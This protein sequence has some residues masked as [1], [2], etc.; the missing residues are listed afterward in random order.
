MPGMTNDTP[1]KMPDI[2]KEPGSDGW[3]TTEVAGAALKR[4]PRT[5]KR[6]IN[7]GEL[8]GRQ[9]KR[10]RAR[11]WEVDVASLKALRDRWVVEGRLDESATDAEIA[12]GGYEEEDRSEGVARAFERIAQELADARSQVADAQARLELTTRAESSTKDELEIERRRRE[13]I[14][15]QLREARTE[16]EKERSKSLWQRFFD[17][18]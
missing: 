3:T 13:H 17:Y 1:D 9:V 14:E 12:A 16:L 10:G 15:Q 4:N 8:V 7:S 18:E 6:L 5:V 11:P 2:R